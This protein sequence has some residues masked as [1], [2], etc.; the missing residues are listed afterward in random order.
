MNNKNKKSSC[1][2]N[3]QSKAKESKARESKTQAH[4]ANSCK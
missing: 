3:A 4:N 1:K 2:N